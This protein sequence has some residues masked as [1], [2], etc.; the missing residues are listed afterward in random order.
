[1]ELIKKP[2][3][4][5]NMALFL[6]PERVEDFLKVILD[7]QEA[8]LR[9]EPG[10][11]Q[12][13]VGRSP[14]DPTRFFLHEEFDSVEAIGE[15]RKTEHYARWAEFKNT[16]PFTQPPITDTYDEVLPVKL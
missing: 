3:F 4:C 16:D 8:T 12:F 15:H 10:A 9:L 13:T 5:V 2:R 11:R 1:M 7:D 14:T 6:K